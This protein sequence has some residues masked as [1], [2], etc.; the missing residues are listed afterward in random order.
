M[1][2]NF[3]QKTLKPDLT[4][5]YQ[6]FGPP[7]PL[8]HGH[9]RMGDDGKGRRTSGAPKCILEWRGGIEPQHSVLPRASGKR[10][11]RATSDRAPYACPSACQQ[12]HKLHQQ[13][14]NAAE[15]AEEAELEAVQQA[16]LAELLVEG[17]GAVRQRRR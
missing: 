8:I 5:S 1:L 11:D 13:S 4:G 6:S 3:D 15:E 12:H 7:A 10:A 14:E 2:N 9:G 16:V 17:V